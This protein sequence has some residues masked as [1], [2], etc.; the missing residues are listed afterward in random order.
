VHE[1][2]ANL[3]VTMAQL[4]NERLQV[5]FD[6]ENAALSVKGAKATIE[7]AQDAL[8]NARERLRLAEGRYESGVGTIIELGD[9]QV[10]LTNAAATLVQAQFNLGSA[11]AQL[12]S[13]LGKR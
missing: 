10:A 2:E 6:V 8:V 5:R 9:A 4:E 11:R 3:G 7:A 12:L 1:A 13:A